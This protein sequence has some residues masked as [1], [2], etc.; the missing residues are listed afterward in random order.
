MK[1]IGLLLCGRVQPPN[2]RVIMG[3]GKQSEGTA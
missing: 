3:E 1:M 2:E